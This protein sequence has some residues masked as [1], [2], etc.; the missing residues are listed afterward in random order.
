M[1]SSFP[2]SCQDAQAEVKADEEA[3]MLCR[4]RAP[5]PWRMECR[6]E[7]LAWGRHQN[8]SLILGACP[9]V[10]VLLRRTICDHLRRS[11]PA[12]KNRET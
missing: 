8:A 1:I 9:T 6:Y 10:T 3:E 12:P 5:C 11:R 7:S 4:Y 2:G